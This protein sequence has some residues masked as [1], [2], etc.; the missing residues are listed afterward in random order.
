MRRGQTAAGRSWQEDP[1]VGALTLMVSLRASGEAHGV[2]AVRN[3]TTGLYT[4]HHLPT[5]LAAGAG[6]R[7]LGT[8]LLWHA[9]EVDADIQAG[10]Y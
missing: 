9:T 7:Q 5:V 6:R 8:A 10:Q 2:V 4:F 1:A 3:T